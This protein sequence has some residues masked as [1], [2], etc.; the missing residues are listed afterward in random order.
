MNSI[1]ALG[2]DSTNFFKSVFRTVVG[3]ERAA[4]PKSRSDDDEYDGFEKILITAVKWAVDEH[5]AVPTGHQDWAE[6][7][8]LMPSMVARICFDVKCLG[9]ATAR[10]IFTP[11]LV[12]PATR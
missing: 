10:K 3:F 2:D 6:E 5:V 7:P 1:A 4:R 9:F 12:T 8:R 11:S